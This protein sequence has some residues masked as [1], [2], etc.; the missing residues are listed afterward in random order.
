MEMIFQAQVDSRQIPLS[1][2][3]FEIEK[4]VSAISHMNQQYTSDILGNSSQA[5]ELDFSLGND[6]LIAGGSNQMNI[7]VG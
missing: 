7:R 1:N 2:R 3:E 6:G 5:A 4:R